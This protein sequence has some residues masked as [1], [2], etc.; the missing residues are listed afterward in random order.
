MKEFTLAIIINA[1]WV[2]FVVIGWQTA[3]RIARKAVAEH[4]RCKL[5]KA[6][7]VYIAQLRATLRDARLWLKREASHIANV[8]CL[9]T[10]IES[11][12]TAVDINGKPLEKTDASY[13]TTLH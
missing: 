3:A 2:A 8:Q 10:R 5:A 13:N 12:T 7:I 6:R 9:I 4:E 11:L 1:I